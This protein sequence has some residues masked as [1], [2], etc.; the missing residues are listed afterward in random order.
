MIE[1]I[2]KTSDRNGTPIN[3]KV[4]MAVQGFVG[5]ETV[6]NADGSITET[7]ADG[8]VKTTL[9]NPDGSI[10]EMFV[11]EKE[12]TKTTTFDSGKIK[13]VIT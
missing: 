6:I 11:G 2:D 3:R 8:E 7:N 13:E 5:C 4:M 12:I 10:T 9:F 1:F